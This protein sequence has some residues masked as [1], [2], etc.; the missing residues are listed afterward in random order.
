MNKKNVEEKE[1]LKDLIKSSKNERNE[2]FERA[3]EKKHEIIA[4]NE[5]EIKG[6][7]ERL[8]EWQNRRVLLEE[9]W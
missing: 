7:N 3:L 9:M 1:E 8:V 5:Q 4:R 2:D 6:C